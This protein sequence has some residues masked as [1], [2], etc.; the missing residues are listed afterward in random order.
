M[1]FKKIAILAVLLAA[2]GAAGYGAW[3]K[4]MKP[5]ET[6]VSGLA[7]KPADYVGNVVV[8]GVSGNV[9][10]EKGVFE[11]KDEK[12][13]CTI[14]IFVP[15]TDAQKAEFKLPH[16]YKGQ[17]PAPGQSLKVSASLEQTSDGFV[18]MVKDV[19]SGGDT[20]ITRI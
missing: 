4:F 3:D 15:A 17:L 10:P 11:L 1:D 5:K 14:Y 20:I 12:G 6:T 16:T 9:F 2:V 19:N 13:C 8:T 18:L 7:G